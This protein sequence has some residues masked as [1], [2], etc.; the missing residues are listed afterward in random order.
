M[1][2]IAP[3]VLIFLY[4]RERLPD[5]SR[6]RQAR[7]VRW[8]L[9]SL[10]AVFN[11]PWVLVAVRMLSGSLWG[12]GRIPYIAPWIAWQLM[13][14]VFCGLVCVYLLAKGVMRSEERRVGKEC[15]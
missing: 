7:V 6:P 11:F 10:F 14:W 3:Q 9:A 2:F 13:G 4:L 1:L 12:V 15:H 5:P 8:A